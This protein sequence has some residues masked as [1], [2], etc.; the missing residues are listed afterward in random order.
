MWFQGLLGWF[1]LA[2]K[3]VAS[4]T[5]R[6][7]RWNSTSQSIKIWHG[8]SSFATRCPSH[9][10]VPNLKPQ[11]NAPLLEIVPGQVVQAV[12]VW[13]FGSRQNHAAAAWTVGTGARQWLERS[14][15][16]IQPILTPENTWTTSHAPCAALT[17]SMP[18]VA[19][20]RRVRLCWLRI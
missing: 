11:I 2:V 7:T 13:F 17:L 16:L 1:R 15:L 20:R 12:A 19:L 4:A 10:R 3:S 14:N 6:L 5:R 8:D 18:H 9:T